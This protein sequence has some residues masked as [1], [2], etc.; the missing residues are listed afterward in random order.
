[1][2]FVAPIWLILLPLFLLFWALFEVG[3]Y[4]KRQKDLKLWGHKLD[5]K[6]L[7]KREHPFTRIL[8]YVFLGSGFVAL[9]LALAR[10][11]W[12]LKTEKRQHQGLCVLF[13]LDTSKSMLA[14]DVRPNRLQLAKLSVLELLQRLG[15]NRVGLI[16]FSGGAFLQCP[17][18]KD[19]GAFKLAL[20]AL[21]TNVIP[22]GG[23]DIA[24]A[25]RVAQQAFEKGNTFKY[26]LLITDGEDL[27]A[28]GINQA[29][30][31]AKEGII[32][33]T[34]GVGSTK[35]D[36]IPMRNAEGRIEYLKD[37]SGNYVTTRLDEKTLEEIAKTTKGFYVPLGNAGEGL[38]QIYETTLRE[39]PKESFESVEQKP[40]ERYVFFAAAALLAFIL[41]LSLYARKVKIY[42]GSKNASL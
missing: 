39:L 28:E 19:Y 15:G 4:F 8:H 27:S 5:K 6:G 23:T 37:E 13:A 9:F 17:L 38:K 42:A 1:M 20:D 30:I 14:E 34:V 25:L 16:A 11:Q 18:T 29:K 32:V 12:G 7:V 31:A 22:K 40:I 2:K 24:A 41:E 3:F 26:L 33:Y 36:K 21:D 10:P 35:G